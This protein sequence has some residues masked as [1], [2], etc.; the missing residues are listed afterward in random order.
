MSR[1][2][3]EIVRGTFEAFNSEDIERVLSRADPD[4]EAVV[5]PELSAEPDTYRGHDGLRLYFQSFRDAMQ[6]VRFEPEQFL[7]AGEFVVTV[8]RL[9][10]KGRH[11]DIA[12]EQRISQVWTIRDGKAVRVL[13]F[14]SLAQAL[15]AAG[16]SS[17]QA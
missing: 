1:H 16:L 14:G 3:V 9:T 6:E 2:N 11:T 12:V 5:P 15:A 13:T 4:F 10:A 8:V 17:E 7:E